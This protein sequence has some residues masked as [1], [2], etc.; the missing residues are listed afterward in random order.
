MIVGMSVHVWCVRAIPGLE[1]T[2]AVWQVGSGF[3]Y[4]AHPEFSIGLV[5]WG[6]E[7]YRYRRGHVIAGCDDISFV[8]PLEPHGSTSASDDGYAYRAF[9][10]DPELLEQIALRMGYS[11]LPSFRTMSVSDA[12]LARRL[13][14]FH[15]DLEGPISELEAQSR[16]LDLIHGLLSR[17]ADVLPVA[18]SEGHEPQAVRQVRE[19]LESQL[20]ENISLEYLSEMV[21]LSAF[22]VAHVFKREMGFAPHEYQNMRRVGLARNLLRS[23]FSPAQAALEVGFCDQSHLNRY[24]KRYVGVTSGRYAQ[25]TRTF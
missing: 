13:R 8:N 2:R 11:G 7:R 22:H 1:L 5:E 10:P 23:G 4:E 24:F 16:W 19:V 6:A 18:F 14:D 20:A 12:G 21:G 9:N 3:A 17:H 25:S 15:R